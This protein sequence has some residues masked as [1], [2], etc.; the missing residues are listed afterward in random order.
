MK[1]THR[2]HAHSLTLSDVVVW[3]AFMLGVVAFLLGLC[4]LAWLVAP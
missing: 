1:R 3:T 4:A 2:A